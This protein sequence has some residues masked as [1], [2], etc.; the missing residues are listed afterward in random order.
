MSPFLTLTTM[1]LCS[2]TGN[3]HRSIQAYTSVMPATYSQ[4]VREKTSCINT[5]TYYHTIQRK[6][7]Q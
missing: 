5:H 3:V 6:H 7:I 4:K 2:R 1:T